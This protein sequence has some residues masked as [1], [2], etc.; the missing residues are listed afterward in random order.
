MI[1]WRDLKL[2]SV[3]PFKPHGNFIYRYY[4]TPL[5]WILSSKETCPMP[6]L[7]IYFNRGFTIYYPAA[8]CAYDKYLQLRIEKEARLVSR[9]F[10]AL[11]V[12]SNSYDFF[13][14]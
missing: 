12:V 4:S 10:A 7:F 6:W 8:H 3:S 11:K 14:C 1:N 9:G 13:T 5:Q 2:G